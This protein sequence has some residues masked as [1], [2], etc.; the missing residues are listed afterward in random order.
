[1]ATQNTPKHSDQKRPKYALHEGTCYQLVQQDLIDFYERVEVPKVEN[2]RPIWKGPLLSLTVL[3]QAISF[4][5][6]SFAD[7]DSEQLAYFY[8]SPDMTAIRLHVPFQECHGMTVSADETASPEARAAA[9]EADGV[10]GW[11]FFG[12]IHHHCRSGAFASGT[13]R[14][15]EENREGLHITVGNIDTKEVTFHARFVYSDNTWESRILDWVHVDEEQYLTPQGRGLPSEIKK[16]VIKYLVY[17]HE[18]DPGSFPP[19]WLNRVKKKVQSQG[20][21]SNKKMADKYWDTF[22]SKDSVTYAKEKYSA[23]TELPWEEFPL[24]EHYDVASEMSLLDYKECTKVLASLSLDNEFTTLL[25]ASRQWPF[26]LITH[27]LST[28]PKNLGSDEITI[29][30]KVLT[31]GSA[32]GLNKEV[33]LNYFAFLDCVSAIAETECITDLFKNESTLSK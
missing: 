8:I 28:L 11:T 29:R 3:H 30:Q 25:E 4:F 1:M 18:K 2:I 16:E 20:F 6:E 27:V 10:K 12:S 7:N 13:D 14:S 31:R 22:K 5:R 26:E 15:D 23:Q 9:R 24:S 32:R 17:N 21:T 33:L 19:A